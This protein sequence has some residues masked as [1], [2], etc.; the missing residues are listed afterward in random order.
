MISN[1]Y[2]QMPTG[3]K[4]SA[5]GLAK[6]VNEKLQQVLEAHPAVDR[7]ERTATDQPQGRL[8]MFRG[9]SAELQASVAAAVGV[10]MG[11]PVYK[12]DGSAV[13][14][15]YIGQTEKNLD[16]LFKKA[17]DRNAVLFFDEADALFG[18]RTNVRDSHDRYANA[19]ANYLLA[20]AEATGVTLIA[21]V[22]ARANID[23][24]FL[25]RMSVVDFGA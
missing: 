19:E 17:V 18:K 8:L 23:K 4:L 24:A 11:S 21:G 13:V 1:A 2:T 9:S 5:L 6:E 10:E 20:K 16:R 3:S 7:N 22:K 15:K 14:S 25:R 12:V